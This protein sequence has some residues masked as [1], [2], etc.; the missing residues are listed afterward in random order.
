MKKIGP[1][2]WGIAIVVLGVILGGN[3]IGLFNINVFFDGW[4]TLFIIV[5]SAISLITE[6]DKISSLVFLAVGVIFLLAAQN[7]FS[8]DV[9]W[10]VALAVFLVAVGL[11]I[12]F[13]SVFHSN[14]DKEL[15]KKIREFDNDKVMDS[16]SAIFSG[17]ERVYNDET[18]S[19]SNLV[20]V[21][22]GVDLDLRKAKF[23]KDTVIRAFCLF[24]GIDLKVPE[25]TQIKIRSRF[26]FGGASDERKGSTGKE[27]YTIYLD[28]VGG[29]GGIN[30]IDKEKKN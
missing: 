14:S 9:A 8:Y 23:T 2:I 28:A 11:G 19:G 1:I 24:G 27:K 21:F 12:I 5:P 22:G 13:K 17:S 30:I 6:K 4:W 20:A 18:F 15:E 7:V 29:F 3:A 10:K 16:Q 26:I 25:G